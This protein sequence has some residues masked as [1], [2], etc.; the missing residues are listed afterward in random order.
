MLADPG[1]SRRGVRVVVIFLALQVA[2][3]QVPKAGIHVQLANAAV[4]SRTLAEGLSVL[5]G[6]EVVP[7]TLHD[8]D[9][10]NSRLHRLYR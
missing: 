2:G 9:R 5:G 10:G 8:A 4:T 6:R 7:L 1:V 3:E